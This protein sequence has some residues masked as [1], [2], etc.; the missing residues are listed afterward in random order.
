MTFGA[1]IVP[2][3]VDALIA[4]SAR[5]RREDTNLDFEVRNLDFT[6]VGRRG[7]LRS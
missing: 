6:Q 3:L 1:A 2:P 7:T 4:T 5:H